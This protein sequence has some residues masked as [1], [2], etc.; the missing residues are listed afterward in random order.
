MAFAEDFTQFF[1]VTNGFAVVGTH[2]G[3]G[4]NGI[5]DNEYAGDGVMAG[6][7][8]IFTLSSSDASNMTEGDQITINA[9]VYLIREKQQDGTGVTILVLEEN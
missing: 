4:Y 2:S 5:F 3:T 7:I 6:T 9:V 1:D 8:P